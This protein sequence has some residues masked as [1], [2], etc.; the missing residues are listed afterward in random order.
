MFSTRNLIALVGILN[1]NYDNNLRA[2]QA[3][4]RNIEA[5]S[6]EDDNNYTTSEII[7]SSLPPRILPKVIGFAEVTVASMDS[8]FFRQNFRMKRETFDII[9][10]LIKNEQITKEFFPN[11]GSTNQHINTPIKFEKA[12]LITIWY[13]SNKESMREVGLIFN[14]SKSTAHGCIH[15]VVT[16][17]ASLA[18]K[19]IIWPKEDAEFTKLEN[20]FFRQAGFPKVI[21]AIDG[22]HINIQPPSDQEDAYLDRN[23]NHSMILQGICSF[24]KIFL[25]ISVG[26][27]GS[28]HDARVLKFSEIFKETQR[29]IKINFPSQEFHLLGDSAYPLL[30]W[31]MTPFKEPRT[32]SLTT[33]QRRYNTKHSST[34]VVIENTF[35]L[36]QNRFKKLHLVD[37]DLEFIP[38]IITACCVLHNICESNSD[39]LEEWYTELSNYQIINLGE[40]ERQRLRIP[41]SSFAIEKRN[42][43]A[44][45]L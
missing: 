20:D 15:K 43:I 31:L 6:E 23:R 22:C 5:V 26:F 11:E 18:S 21:G 14:V 32:R 36:L 16:I 17:L 44:A 24:E 33:M 1:D 40:N 42:R 3:S 37:T 19:F 4:I 29:D 45:N 9:H 10:D 30:P 35:G 2:V 41:Q 8:E 25:N 12:L 27:A 39:E 34:R 38:Y 28:A 7:L 13:L